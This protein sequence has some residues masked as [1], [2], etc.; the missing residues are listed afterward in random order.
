MT[1]QGITI[2]GIHIE[3]ERKRVKNVNLTIYPPDGRVRISAPHRMSEKK[4]HQVI[5]SKL[6]WIKRHRTQIKSKAWVKPYKYVSGERHAFMGEVYQLDV[7]QHDAAPSIEIQADDKII[8]RVRRG[9]RREKRE[10]V[11]REWY[12]AEL[13]KLIPPLIARWEPVIGVEVAEWGVKR[14]KTRWGSCN[15]KAHR[16]WVNLELAKHPIERLEYIVVHE[17][18]HLLEHRHNKRFY[19]YMDRFLP[20]WRQHREALKV[21]PNSFPSRIG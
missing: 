15:T 20:E 21:A 3:L 18:V 6:P 1:K 12:R 14:M 16:I 5:R 7:I 13:K 8:L 17:M 19:A 10:K 9:S 2:D 11:L 4:L